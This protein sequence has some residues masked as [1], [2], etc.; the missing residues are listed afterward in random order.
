MDV[1][2]VLYICRAL[3]RDGT[4][5][6]PAQVREYLDSLGADCRNLENALNDLV[7]AGSLARSEQ[8]TFE[9]SDAGRAKAGDFPDKEQ[10]DSYNQFML[11]IW[12][13]KAYLDFCE[14][15]YGFRWCLLNSLYKE[16]YQYLFHELQ[17]SS[18][19]TVLDLGCGSGA[20]LADLVK[21]HTCRGIGIDYARDLIDILK[22]RHSD[23]DFYD[24]DIEGVRYAPV[25]ADVIISLD[26]LYTCR[27]LPALFDGLRSKCRRHMYV[28]F[29]Q[30]L[31]DENGDR[32]TLQGENT[33]LA[34]ALQVNGLSYSAVDVSSDEW[35]LWKHEESILDKHRAAFELEGS[36]TIWD[37]R[38]ADTNNM[39]KL[40]AEHRAARFIYKIDFAR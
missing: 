19:D 1:Q 20:V 5:I 8:G 38:V 31:D 12:H 21:R 27:N 22:K 35:G 4:L 36:L 14:D 34:R 6:E 40:F 2:F 23:I 26:G 9:I 37:G 11:K 18:N 32:A 30:S 24:L 15:L 39:L 28:F 7:E 25:E 33:D 10:R 13:S 17:V 16:Q 3:E 29:T